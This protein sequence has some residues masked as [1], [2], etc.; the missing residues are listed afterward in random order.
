ML[1]FLIAFSKE[2]ADVFLSLTLS[3]A[4]SVILVMTVGARIIAQFPADYFITPHQDKA[5]LQHFH[6]SIRVFIPLLKNITG[7]LLIVTGIVMLFIPGQ[8]LLT[9][10]AG[11]VLTDFPGKLRCELWL[12]R[13]AKVCRSTNWLGR[14]SG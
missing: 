14:R 9:M 5:Y 7:V 13:R 3:S 11:V 12:V 2:Y 10:L 6:P 1:N 8:G 4:L